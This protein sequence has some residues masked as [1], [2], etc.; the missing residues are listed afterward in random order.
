[1]LVYH[2][3]VG[4]FSFVRAE[5]VSNVQNSYDIPVYWLFQRDPYI[6]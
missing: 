2:S 3:E 6:G 1:M 5:H 4:K